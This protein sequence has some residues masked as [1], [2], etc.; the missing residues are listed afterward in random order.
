LLINGKK[1][2][3]QILLVSERFSRQKHLEITVSLKVQGLAVNFLF[4]SWSAEI[5]NASDKK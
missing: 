4:Y 1:L 3:T 2:V 5:F